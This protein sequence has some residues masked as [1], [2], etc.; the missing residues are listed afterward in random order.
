MYPHF[1]SINLKICL[2]C[3]IMFFIVCY[4][5][6]THMHLATFRIFMYNPSS[7][8]SY[9]IREFY[10][11]KEFVIFIALF[12]FLALGMHMPQWLSHP[13]EHL[14]N[15]QTHKMPYHPLLFTFILYLIIGFIRLI[16]HSIK[17]LFK[18]R[19]DSV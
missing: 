19:H 15:L 2:V 3:N 11:K 12:C 4:Y 6:I 10:V 18:R 9:D 5:N 8:Y 1:T 14:H 7:N 17:K 13:I 16:I